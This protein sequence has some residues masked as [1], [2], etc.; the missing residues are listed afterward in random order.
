MAAYHFVDGVLQV[1]GEGGV[2]ATG[3]PPEVNSESTAELSGLTC[4]EAALGSNSSASCMVT[5][6]NTDG[7]TVALSSST[8]ELM[9]PETVTVYTGATTASFLVDTG[10]VCEAKTATIMATLNGVTKTV[11][12][13]LEIEP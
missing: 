5:L 11:S 13:S 6:S 4:S 8:D 3:I 9:V 1:E 12:V 7:G 10:S 2:L